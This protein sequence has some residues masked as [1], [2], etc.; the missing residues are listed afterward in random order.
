MSGLRGSTNNSNQ[1]CKVECVRNK[2]TNH[3]RNISVVNA[4][5]FS[6]PF[7]DFRITA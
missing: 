6:A 3:G 5:L 2:K 7:D 1:G 4:K